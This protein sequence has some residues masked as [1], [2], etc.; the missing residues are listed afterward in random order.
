MS[1]TVQTVSNV[2]TLLLLNH[3]TNCTNRVKRTHIITI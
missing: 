3:V 1:Q 2:H